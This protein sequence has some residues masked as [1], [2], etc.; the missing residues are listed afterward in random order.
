MHEIAGGN[1]GIVTSFTVKTNPLNNLQ[2]VTTIELQW[3]YGQAVQVFDAV[4]LSCLLSL[5]RALMIRPYDKAVS[6]VLRELSPQILQACTSEIAEACTVK[7][8]AR[9]EFPASLTQSSFLGRQDL[10]GLS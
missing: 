4:S 9:A 7:V 1:L 10:Q 6:M 2:K 8:L 5:L 3:G